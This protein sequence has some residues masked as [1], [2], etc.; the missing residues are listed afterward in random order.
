MIEISDGIEMTARL[1]G[2][3]SHLGGPSRAKIV[4]Q[5]LYHIDLIIPSALSR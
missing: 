2:K 1:W 5:T 3:S 4:I